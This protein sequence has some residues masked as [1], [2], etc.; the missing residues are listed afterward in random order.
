MKTIEIKK[1]NK[2]TFKIVPDNYVEQPAELQQRD[3]TTS[4]RKCLGY[5]DISTEDW[6]RIFKTSSPCKERKVWKEVDQENMK[7]LKN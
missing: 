1:G 4:D 7:Q 5:S 3:L 2:T 6:N